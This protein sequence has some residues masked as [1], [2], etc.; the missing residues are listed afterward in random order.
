MEN[1][2]I[3]EFAKKIGVSV[4]TLQRWDREGILT[5][6][7]TPTNRRYYTEEQLQQYRGS[8]ASSLEEKI[9]MIL[10]SNKS[11]DEKLLEI[12]GLIQKE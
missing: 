12:E 8:K 5:A 2:S 4:N 6:N 3:G 7:R 10:T 9:S 11:S 1:Y